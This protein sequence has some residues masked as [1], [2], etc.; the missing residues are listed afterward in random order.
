MRVRRTSCDYIGYRSSEPI[1]FCAALYG[2]FLRSSTVPTNH[3]LHRSS[4]SVIASPTAGRT[5]CDYTSSFGMQVRFHSIRLETLIP[6][7]VILHFCQILT[8]IMK[9]RLRP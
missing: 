8:F 5:S 9:I 7:V 1:M 2:R 4:L 3:V 6:T